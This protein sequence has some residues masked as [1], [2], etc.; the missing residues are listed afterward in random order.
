[1]TAAKA[2][3]KKRRA[4][5]LVAVVLLVLIVAAYSALT[6]IPVQMAIY[7][8]DLGKYDNVIAI[9]YGIGAPTDYMIIGDSS[10]LFDIPSDKRV[11]VILLGNVPPRVHPK[12]KYGTDFTMIQTK[13]VC[14]VEYNGKQPYGDRWVLDTYIVTD[15]APLGPINRCGPSWL[16]P[17]W[18]TN[19]L[20]VLIDTYGRRG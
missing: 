5:R 20:D 8:D 6:Y 12:Y 11:P 13:Y 1:V 19:Y 3:K 10:G 14:F 9:Q 4:A 2:G 17:R 15:W 16:E 18:Y 7:P